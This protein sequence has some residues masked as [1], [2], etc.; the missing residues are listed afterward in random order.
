LLK[1][2]EPKKVEKVKGTWQLEEMEIRNRQTGSR[3]RIEFN[4][5]E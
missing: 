1:E 3:T 5:K 4:L 2:F